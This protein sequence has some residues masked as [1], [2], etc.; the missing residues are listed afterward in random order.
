MKNFSNCNTIGLQVYTKQLSF[1]NQKINC[2]Y[3]S[4]LVEKAQL[5]S[6]MYEQALWAMLYITCAQQALNV[7]S[8]SMILMGV[9]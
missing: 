2:H 3:D 8:I 4:T 1:C 6:N 7:A 9:L 5:M